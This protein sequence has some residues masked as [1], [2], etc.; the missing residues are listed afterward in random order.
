MTSDITKPLE[1]AVALIALALMLGA[2]ASDQ[3]PSQVQNLPA[4]TVSQTGPCCGP[5]TPA[6]R[7]ILWS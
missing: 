1:N 6:A 5:I 3:S 7:N 2:C 4:V